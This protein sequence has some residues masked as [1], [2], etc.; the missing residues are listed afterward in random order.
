MEREIKGI[1]IPI[2][3]WQSRDLSWNEKVLLM[4]VDSFTSK[5]HDC[6]FSNEYIA[7]LLGVKEDTASKMVSSLIRKGYI[8]QTRFDGRKRYLE[9]CIEIRCRVGEKSDADYDKNHTLGM[10]KIID[11]NINNKQ[12]NKISFIP[13]KPKEVAEYAKEREFLDAEGFAK[14]FC[15]Y[16]EMSKWHLSN[17]KPMKDWKRAVLTWEPNNK[18]RNFSRPTSTAPKRPASPDGYNFVNDWQ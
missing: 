12:D 18:Y 16:Y 17:G 11:N 2:E 4:E 6:Y 13:P 3:I 9:T 15:E 5:G 14:H 1:F 10:S 7:T 8:R